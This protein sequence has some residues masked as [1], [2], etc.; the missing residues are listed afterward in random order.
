MAADSSSLRI[1]LL[2]AGRV[3]SHLGPALWRAGH[4]VAWVWN[5][6]PAGAATL[7]DQIPGAVAA[8]GP[9]LKLLP[10]VDLYIVAVPDAAVAA[11]L[12]AAALPA[13]A[14]VVH[15]AGALPLSVFDG[16]ANLRGGVFYPLQ[17]FSPGRAI[18][19][20]TVPLCV[21]AGAATDEATLLAL[22]RSLSKTVFT[23]ATPQRQALH[24]AAV[25]A[26]NFTNHLLGI[27]HALTQ[28]ARVPFE[29][30]HPLIR[31]TVEKALHHPPFGVQTGPA[32]RHDSATLDF[33][34]A[35]LAPHPGWLTVYNELTASI[36][37][38][39]PGAGANN[40]EPSQL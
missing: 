31:E 38:Q 20:T 33:H 5:R 9:D 26:S 21:E 40:G 3:A 34:R 1:G 15:T 11:V 28:Q 7:A 22:A 36:Q 13:G 17:T 6:T 2:G 18:D 30:L 39:N 4:H 24:V 10:P 14:L 19:W 23:V 12:A 27:S 29:L 35:A 32:V 16:F 8:T 37:A 25:F